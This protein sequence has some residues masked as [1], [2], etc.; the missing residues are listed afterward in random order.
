MVNIQGAPR[1]SSTW[2]ACDNRSMPSRA[3]P[4]TLAKVAQAWDSILEAIAAGEEIKVACK[5]HGFTREMVYA[6]YGADKEL[7]AQWERARTSSADS[8]MDEALATA[9]NSELDPSHARV[10][11]DT[12][13]WAA[14]KRNPDHYAERTRQDINV[15]TL[16]YSAI[17]ARAEARLAQQRA[18][19][20]IDGRTG[21]L[22][23]DIASDALDA[24]L[25]DAA[26]SLF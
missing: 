5:A 15:K 9:R 13:K 21:A 11:V 8:F 26:K 14:A 22:L 4:A 12:L 20:L 19:A 24:V 18:P 1:P 23:P 6:Y 2:W 7:R 16:D 25:S 10:L 3:S 17:L